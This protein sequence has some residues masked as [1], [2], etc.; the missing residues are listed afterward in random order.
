MKQTGKQAR[1]LTYNKS[2]KYLDAKVT[3][4]ITY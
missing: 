4:A 1:D 2:L 3:L